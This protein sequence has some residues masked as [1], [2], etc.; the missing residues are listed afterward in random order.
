LV[1]S[2]TSSTELALLAR[3]CWKFGE[4]ALSSG[5]E[6]AEN[7]KVVRRDAHQP[8]RVRRAAGLDED[9]GCP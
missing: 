9:T 5:D 6:I 8:S 4:A 3:A 7:S 2:S 1:S